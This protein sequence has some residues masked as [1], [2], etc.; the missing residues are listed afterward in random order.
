MKG[1]AWYARSAHNFK[2]KLSTMYGIE[3]EA[4]HF[5][6]MTVQAIRP[7]HFAGFLH[8]HLLSSFGESQSSAGYCCL[9]NAGCVAA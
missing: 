9:G 6:M 5:V 8:L 1:T 3:E 4:G 2:N 7:N